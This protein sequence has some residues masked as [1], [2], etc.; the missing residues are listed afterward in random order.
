MKFR[1]TPPNSTVNRMAR[2]LNFLALLPTD[3]K[4]VKSHQISESLGIKPSQFRQDFHYFGCFGRPGR[5]YD[6]QVL[7]GV[8]ESILGVDKPLGMIILGLG[9]LGTALTNYRYFERL[10]IKLLGLFDTS[11][12]IIGLSV[13]GIEIMHPNDLEEFSGKHKIELAV[14]T[15]PAEAAQS[16]CDLLIR[17]GIKGIWN[18]TPIQMDAPDGFHIRNEQPALG[19]LALTFR[20]NQNSEPPVENGDF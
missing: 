13:R 12:K 5:G 7:I 11:P 20:L 16:T 1:R 3:Q 6:K 2:Y 8:L 19:L 9:H 10:N 14:I 15:T 18:F 17:L 4:T